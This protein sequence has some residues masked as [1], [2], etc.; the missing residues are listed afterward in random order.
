MTFYKSPNFFKFYNVNWL[1]T[2]K[3]ILHLQLL[4]I[5]NYEKNIRIRFRH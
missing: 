3:I 5:I 1:R 2:H 4:Q